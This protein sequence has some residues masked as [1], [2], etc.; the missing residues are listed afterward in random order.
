MSHSTSVMIHHRGANLSKQQTDFIILLL[1]KAGFVMQKYI[2]VSLH[3]RQL[4]ITYANSQD[5]YSHNGYI[6]M[7]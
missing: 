1:H 3:Q 7:D 6:C 4:G 2:L 5:S